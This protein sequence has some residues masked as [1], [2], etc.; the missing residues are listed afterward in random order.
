MPRIVVDVLPEPTI[1]SVVVIF[2]NA[3]APSVKLST[4]GW[5]YAPDAKLIV[6]ASPFVFALEI[7]ATRHPTS[8]PAHTKLAAPAVSDNPGRRTMT[9]SP[10][11]SF[12]QFHR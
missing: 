6:F 7:A 11:K 3:F 4:A 5:L 2:G 9:R 12:R 8:P 1:V 10:M